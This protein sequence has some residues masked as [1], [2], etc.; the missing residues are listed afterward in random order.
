M[1]CSCSI[2]SLAVAGAFV[3]GVAAAAGATQS[4]TLEPIVVSASGSTQNVSDA[5]ASVTVIEQDELAHMPVNN[6]TDAIRDIPGINVVGS[7]PSKSDIS[8]R[9]LSGDYTLLLVNGR[10]QNTRESRP[11]GSGGFE[12]GFMPPM[13]AIE[14]IEV[15]RGPMSSLYGSDAMGGIVNVITKDFT[16]EW[17]GSLSLGGIL[18]ESGDAGNTANSSF[19]LSG[20]LVDNK[21]GVQ[22][23]G[24]GNIRGEDRI[25]GGYNR[26]EDKNIVTR[27]A[28]LPTDNQRVI[29]E[30]GR[31]VQKRRSTPGKSIDA[32]TARGTSIKANTQD[33]TIGSRNHWSL[34]HTGDWNVMTSELSVYQENAKREV[35]NDGVYDS[36][37]PEITQTVFDAR[38]VVPFSVHKLTFGGQYQRGRL[39]DDSTTGLKR[40]VPG[41]INMNQYALFVEDEIALRDNLAL[42]L[43]ARMDDHEQ[44]GVHWSP[45]AYLVYH[46]SSRFTVRGGISKGF[47][48]PGLRELSPNYGT[49]TEGGRGIIYGNPDLKPETSTS[50]E[51]GF[52]YR[53]P[54]GYHASVTFFNTDFRDKLTSYSTGDK[55][56][57]SGLNNYVY[58]N[59]GKANI[60][61]IELAAGMPITTS[62]KLDVNYTYLDS[63]RKSDDETYTSGESLKGQ[64]LEMT[65]RHSASAKL[66]WQASDS[67][68]VYVKAAYSGKQAWANQRNGFGGKGGTRYRSGFM[69]ADAGGNY[70]VNKNLTVGFAVLNIGNQRMYGIDTAGNWA[71]EDGR[72]YWLNLNMT[73]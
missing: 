53:D 72:R 1:K 50:Q 3:P 65:P 42:T 12:A 46:P 11:N 35:R 8:I 29:L 5:P 48:T 61:G 17:T 26:H 62:L 60:K 22:I 6:L 51:I 56:P 66:S 27:F 20:P 67:L 37:R 9:G 36:R 30:A 16:P 13:A 47:R 69:T 21:L 24:G 68:D 10:R 49:A 59:V 19:F 45:R 31:S 70:Q 39:R 32:Y 73:Y 63:K 25:V 7:N 52:E 34:T 38:F 2:L 15:V 58:A 33:D 55:D 44:Y 43:G 57:V 18:Q 4:T 40:T 28:W 71:V 64:P 14:R 23:Y 41:K 54:D